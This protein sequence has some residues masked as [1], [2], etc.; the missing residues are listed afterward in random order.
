MNKRQVIL[1][2][3]EQIAPGKGQMVADG[4][5]LTEGYL[6]SAGLPSGI[7]GILALMPV[8]EQEIEQA[9]VRHPEHADRLWQ[10]GFALCMPTGNMSR[11]SVKIYRKHCQE[12]L[13]RLALGQDTRPGTRAEMLVAF[14]WCSHAAPLPDDWA[15]AYSTLFREVFPEQSEKVGV[16]GHESWSGQVNEVLSEYRRKLTVETRGIPKQKK[17]PVLPGMEG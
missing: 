14:E 8:C 4:M 3:I 12:L 13:D 11:L 2:I 7:S 6:D 10:H 17:Q 1:D 9:Q 15:F 5:G 16:A